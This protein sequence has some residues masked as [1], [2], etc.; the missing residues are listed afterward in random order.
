MKRLVVNLELCYQCHQCVADCSYYY[1]R[2]KN[3]GIERALAKGAQLV[4]CRR[5]QEAFCVN[6]CPNKAL[7]KRPGD[8]LLLRELLLCTSCKTCSLACPFGVITDDILAYQT[9]G[10]DWCLG[11]ANGDGPLCVK[12]CPQQAL[13]YEEVQEDE[14]KN[15][16]VINEYLAVKAIKWSK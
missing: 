13:S 15:I 12:T 16:Y 8:G 7:S 14:Q 9:T 5:C 2:G 4:V 6:S 1:H 10:C 11:R 3:N